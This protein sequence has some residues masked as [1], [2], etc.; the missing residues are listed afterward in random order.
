MCLRRRSPDPHPFRTCVCKALCSL[1]YAFFIMGLALLVKS[2]GAAPCGFGC[3]V[4]RVRLT[5]SWEK[6]CQNM[7]AAGM[8]TMGFYPRNEADLVEQVD[9]ALMIGMIRKDIPII[10]LSNMAPLRPGETNEQ[11][12]TDLPKRVDAARRAS[13]H[14]SEWPEII[15][16]GTDEPEHAEQVKE[17]SRAFHA[18]GYR[19][20]TSLCCT[21]IKQFIPHLDLLIV[22]AS[23]GVLT[24]ENVKAIVD[25][26]KQWGVYNTQ[27]WSASP[28]LM[29]YYSGV[30]TWAMKPAVN[31][32]WEWKLFGEDGRGGPRPEAL[33][34]YAAGVKDY[35]VLCRLDEMRDHPDYDFWPGI[36]T[37]DKE[38]WKIDF[39]GMAAKNKPYNPLTGI[40]R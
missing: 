10:L 8:N 5:E 33:A 37:Y 18:G 23:P 24:P 9:T 4:E 3:Y 32:M 39:Y 17:W 36:C 30:W 21:D 12:W 35:D 20:T 25:A 31:F 2:C 11:G 19:C 15:L 7:K 40:N 6:T 27:L 38:N 26:G 16:Y 14:G 1:M 28:D 29:R 34:G 22:H 13:P